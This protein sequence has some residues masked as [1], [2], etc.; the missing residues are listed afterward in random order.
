MKKLVNCTPHALHIAD[1]NGNVIRTV[2]ASGQ[3]ARVS[4]S[5]TDRDDDLVCKQVFGDVTGLPDPQDDTLVIV[6][7]L[8]LAASDRSDLVAPDTGRAFRNDAGQIVAVPGF[9]RK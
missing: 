5:F 6:S 8:V 4:T 3:V 1:A 9:V 7:A 2:S